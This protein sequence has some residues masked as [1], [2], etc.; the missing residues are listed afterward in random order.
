[1]KFIHMDLGQRRRGDVVEVTLS[2]NAANVRLL[3]TSNLSRYRRGDRH[4]FHGGL[5]KQSPVRLPIPTDGRW[6]VAVDMQGLGGSTR[7]SARVINGSAL[8]PLPPIRE[9]RT[10]LQNIADNMTELAGAVD[11]EREFDVFVSHASEDKNA[12]AR[13]L[14]QALQASGL[15]V[16]Y[17]E[18]ELRVGDSLRRRIDAGIARSRF[19]VVV[20][21]KSFFAKGWAQYELD[22]LVTMK[23][24]GKQVLL[25]LWHEISMD[26]V[27]SASP[28]LADTVALRTSDYSIAEIAN[29]IAAAVRRPRGSNTL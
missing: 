5:A 15:R 4:T 22:G 14:A 6:H 21:S 12:V 25:P 19:G 26:D 10:G 28:S 7:A 11:D 17:D 20:V 29:E 23:V 9:T 3:D 27:R 1:M 16:W 24:S 2:G 18:F 13:P 8:R